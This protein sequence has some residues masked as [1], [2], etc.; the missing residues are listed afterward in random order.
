MTIIIIRMLETMP[1]FLVSG[2]LCLERMQHFKSTLKSA[3]ITIN[4]SEH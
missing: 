4:K 1:R 3:K 2:T